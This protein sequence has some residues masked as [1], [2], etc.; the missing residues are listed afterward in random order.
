MYIYDS[1]LASLGAS[2]TAYPHFLEIDFIIEAA[3]ILD[4]KQHDPT[5]LTPL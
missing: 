1:H 5:K 4:Y 2:P 3:I